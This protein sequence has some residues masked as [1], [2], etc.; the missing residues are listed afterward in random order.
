A[1]HARP[2]VT[3]V[4]TGKP[5]DLGGSSGRREATGRGILFVVDQAIKRFKM[6]P[7]QTRVVVQGSGNV[8][9]IGAM[10]MH[11]G[12]YKVVAIS[13]IHG[14]IYNPKG[15]DISKALEYLRSTRSLEGYDDVEFVSNHE[16]L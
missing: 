13:D 10:L 4:V 16:L 3:A 12:G 8:G 11:E 9:G 7:A 6:T 14:G 15:I 1:M 5:I 2:T